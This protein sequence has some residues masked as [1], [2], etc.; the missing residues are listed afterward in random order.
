MANP[1][2]I[3]APCRGGTPVACPPDVHV[4]EPAPAACEGCG[5][6]TGV[7]LTRLAGGGSYAVCDPC[8]DR[9]R[10]GWYRPVKARHLAA[11]EAS[12]AQAVP[13]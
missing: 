10:K 1:Y 13:A 7:A 2:P 12:E 8:W 3:P 5:S 11:L 9:G 4:H 6:T